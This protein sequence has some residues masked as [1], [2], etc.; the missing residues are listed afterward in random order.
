M[1]VS[2]AQQREKDKIRNKAIQAR[3]SAGKDAKNTPIPSSKAKT[4]NNLPGNVHLLQLER[5]TKFFSPFKKS[6]RKKAPIRQDLMESEK[7][8]ENDKKQLDLKKGQE[9]LKDKQQ[10][11]EN[12]S[13]VLIP[14]NSNPPGEGSENDQNNKSLQAQTRPQKLDFTE[15]E[16]ERERERKAQDL[17]NEQ[18]QRQ[19]AAKQPKQAPATESSDRPEPAEERV[20]IGGRTGGEAPAEEAAQ[21]SE[22]PSHSEPELPEQSEQSEQT[23]LEKKGLEKYQEDYYPE[24]E[25]HG[26]DS[27]WCVDDPFQGQAPPIPYRYDRNDSR[28]T[29][30]GSSTP[31]QT[32]KKPSVHVQASPSWREKETPPPQ[33]NPKPGPGS[34]ARVTATPLLPPAATATGVKPPVD[35]LKTPTPQAINSTPTSASIP[36]HPPVLAT[37]TQAQPAPAAGDANG[38]DNASSAVTDVEKQENEREIKKRNM[39]NLLKQ[40]KSIQASS[41]TP[42][43]SASSSSSVPRM[44]SASTGSTASLMNSLTTAANASGNNSNNSLPTTFPANSIK[45]RSLASLMGKTSASSSSTSSS[46]SS[47]SFGGSLSNLGGNL[48]GKGSKTPSLMSSLLNKGATNNQATPVVIPEAEKQSETDKAKEKEIEVEIQH[49]PFNASTPPPTSS[50]SS[51]SS[52]PPLLREQ[53]KSRA[54]NKDVARTKV[55]WVGLNKLD[56]DPTHRTQHTFTDKIVVYNSP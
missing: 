50:S 51:T 31:Y 18:Y 25:E 34:Q 24:D 36:L 5:I 56:H 3:I 48:S 12:I 20:G 6:V 23:E 38:N 44:T 41:S 40:K 11:D 45:H 16:R 43:S 53:D 35:T 42:V 37:E 32:P 33:H 7:K 22:E 29:R 39:L 49:D 27:D 8:K 26:E 1:C 19:L 4:S 10:I 17:A 2:Q 30:S 47:G 28:Y 55:L 52:F 21:S 9:L 54:R 14:S 15:E 46:S 13:K